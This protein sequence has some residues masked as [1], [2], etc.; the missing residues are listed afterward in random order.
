MPSKEKAPKKAPR[1]KWSAHVTKNSDAMTLQE[2][3]FKKS[4]HAIALSLKRSAEKSDRRKSTPSNVGTMTMTGVRRN[5]CCEIWTGTRNHR[6]RLR[7]HLI[8][9]QRV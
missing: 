7:I 6:P 2:S 1:K 3:V 4:P 8:G 9:C 5:F